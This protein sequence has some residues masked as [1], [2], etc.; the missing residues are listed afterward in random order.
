VGGK[1]LDDKPDTKEGFYIGVG[2]PPE[3]PKARTFLKE[4]NFWPVG[5]ND[6]EFRGLV[7]EYHRRMPELYEVLLGIL[8][9]GMKC[10]A[11]VFDGFMEDAVANIKLLH[12]PPHTAQGIEEI[13]LGGE[14]SPLLFSHL[15]S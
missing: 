5:L 12:Y 10:G 13:S 7:M 2:I 8:A 4:L 1:K 14:L 3:H 11:D 6:D 15:Q 9:E